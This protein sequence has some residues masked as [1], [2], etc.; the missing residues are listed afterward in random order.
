M[1]LYKHVYDYDY[2]LRTE[3]RPWKALRVGPPL[4]QSKYNMADG[5]HLENRYDVIIRGGCFDLD[6]IRQLDTEWHADYGEMV[7]IKTVSRIPIWRTFVFQ[8]RK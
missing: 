8:N 5:C 6:E 2:D 7:E 3:F 1:A 4:P